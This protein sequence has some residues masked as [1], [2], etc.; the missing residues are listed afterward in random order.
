MPFY[1]LK[2][3]WLSPHFLLGQ[4]SKRDYLHHLD[5]SADVTEPPLQIECTHVQLLAVVTTKAL[6]TGVLRAGPLTHSNL[7]DKPQYKTTFRVK[8][9]YPRVKSSLLTL[10]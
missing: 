8:I 4:F 6:F 10:S 7:S 1:S 5:P 2:W 9:C 3:L